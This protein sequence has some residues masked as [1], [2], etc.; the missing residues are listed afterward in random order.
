MAEDIKPRPNYEFVSPNSDTLNQVAKEVVLDEITSSDIQSLIVGMLKIAQGEQG[1]KEHKSMVGLAAPQI[2]VSRRVIIV[3]VNAIGSG[4]K[5][6]LR[7]FINPEIIEKSKD[8][9]EGREGC[10]STGNVCGVVER[11]KSVRIKAYDLDGNEVVETYHGFPARV[12]QHEID[13][14]NGIRFPD[15]ITDNDKLH[16]VEENRFGEYR[17]RWADWG[18]K[19]PREKWEKIKLV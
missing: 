7:V 2:G 8:S 18:E 10:Y 11:S 13:H 4:E 15:I 1:D 6:D 17:E 19:C 9:E 5:P 16:W 14:L 12:F 3:G